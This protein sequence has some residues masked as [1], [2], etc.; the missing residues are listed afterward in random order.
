LFLTLSI[1]SVGAA[2]Q[3]EVFELKGRA[4]Q[5]LIPLVQPFVGADGSVTGM[6]NRLVV[7]TTTDRMIEIRRIITAFDRPLR[8][9]RIQVR[10]SEP[11]ESVRQ[12]IGVSSGNVGIQIG[13]SRDEGI[14]ARR[15]ANRV[16]EENVRTVETLEGEPTLIARGE[17]LPIITGPVYIGG[18]DAGRRS[19]SNGYLDIN[20]GF[21]AIATL[22]DERVR[23]EIAHRKEGSLSNRTID[24]QESRHVVTGKIGQWLPVAGVRSFRG[25]NATGIGRRVD[26]QTKSVTGLWLKVEVL[27]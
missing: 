6:N 13:E 23:I 16:R 2:E 3:M 22:L 26:G 14:T 21:Y 4:P 15:Y 25:D 20:S 27:E 11:S 8:R 12:E 17:S 10:E 7:R 19:I 1:L 5:E 9:L 18:A 24:H